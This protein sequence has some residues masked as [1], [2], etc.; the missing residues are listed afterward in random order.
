VRRRT[1]L[2][3]TGDWPMALVNLVEAAL[4][5]S[6]SPDACSQVCMMFCQPAP[7][8]RTGTSC[9]TQACAARHLRSRWQPP[10]SRT[11]LSLSLSLSLRVSL[12]DP[13]SRSNEA[14]VE[15]AP[16]FAG[17]DLYASPPLFR[18]LTCSSTHGRLGA[19]RA[20]RRH[21][22]TLLLCHSGGSPMPI[23]SSVLGSSLAPPRRS[24]TPS[25]SSRAS[26]ACYYLFQFLRC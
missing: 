8:A 15:F 3:C 16:N 7:S 24:P 14:M 9:K 10:S 6:H 11:T 13:T 21:A 5:W 12:L 17:S 25:S 1:L 23:A 22:I 18:S 20:I 26:V 2:P 19:Y 4:T